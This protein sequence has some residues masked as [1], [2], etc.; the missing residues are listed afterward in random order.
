MKIKLKNFVFSIAVPL[1]VGATAAILTR[2]GME[3]FE[4]L[5]KPPLSPPGWLFPVVWTVLYILIGISRYLVSV[6]EKESSIAETVY[7]VGLAFN[8]LWP[9]I[10]FGFENYIFAFVWLILLWIVTIVNIILFHRISR[11]AAY[12]M[13]PYLLWIT[14]AGYLNLGVSILN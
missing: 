6:S 8:F 10:F 12:L 11:T 1:I 4:S 2:D 5:E 7:Y 9:I 13:I 3:T 14:F